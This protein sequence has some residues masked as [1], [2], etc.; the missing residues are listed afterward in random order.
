[1]VYEDSW[2][3]GASVNEMS[4]QIFQKEEDTDYSDFF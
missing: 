2:L 4:T 1:M 3:L